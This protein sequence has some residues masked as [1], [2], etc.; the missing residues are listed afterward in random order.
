[1]P[2]AGAWPKPVRRTQTRRPRAFCPG[3]SPER[4]GLSG[5]GG[6]LPHVSGPRTRCRAPGCRP[7]S[8]TAPGNR[9]AR[10]RAETAV[11]SD[12]LT[13][14]VRL[15]EVQEAAITSRH[16]YDLAWAVLENVSGSRIQQKALPGELPPAPWSDQ[17]REIEAAVAEGQSRRPEVGE[18]SGRMRAA[19]EHPRRA[20]GK[21][22]HRGRD[23]GL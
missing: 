19:G 7:A 13:V 4:V 1:M 2:A 18:L 5:R 8:R 17:I 16:Q 23:G 22:S 20:G 6:V 3:R 14:E 10:E 21:I 11:K 12:V 9:L 15:A